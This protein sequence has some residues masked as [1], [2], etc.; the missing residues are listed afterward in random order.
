[1]N[2]RAIIV[3]AV[4]FIA[5]V[6]GMFVY[7]RWKSNELRNAEPLP[8]APAVA[9]P[10]EITHIDAKHFFKDGT[11]TVAGEIMMPTPCDLLEAKVAFIAKSIPEKVGLAFTVINNTNGACAQVI[12]P[13][14][15][16]VSFEGTTD[17]TI[18]ATLKGREV[19]LNLVEAGPDE[20]P[21]DFE[22][23]QKG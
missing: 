9:Q 6:I 2:Q 16:K 18:T 10:T 4:L 20:N 22:L 23:F 11:H 14:R 21:D 13:Q 3:A 12:T 8:P 17:A 5:I 19:I 15:F 1:M 7:A